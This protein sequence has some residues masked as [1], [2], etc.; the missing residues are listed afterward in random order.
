MKSKLDRISNPFDLLGFLFQFLFELYH[1]DFF[2][3]CSERLKVRACAEY[4]PSAKPVRKTKNWYFMLWETKNILTFLIICLR[5][6]PEQGHAIWEQ[7]WSRCLLEWMGV[8]VC[9]HSRS[10]L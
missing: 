8:V 4:S 5:A 9:H 6:K 3:T 7:T 10:A 2:I 1:Y